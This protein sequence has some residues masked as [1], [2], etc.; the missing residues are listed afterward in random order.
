MVLKTLLYFLCTGNL[1]STTLIG[2]EWKLCPSSPQATSRLHL[3][4]LEKQFSSEQK[5]HNHVQSN[6][7]LLEGRVKYCFPNAPESGSAKHW[8]RLWPCFYSRAI[9]RGKNLHLSPD[10]KDEDKTDQFPHSFKAFTSLKKKKKYLGRGE[11]S[12]LLWFWKHLLRPILGEHLKVI[13]YLTT[14][15][16]EYLMRFFILFI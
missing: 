1:T 7:R 9:T 4:I 16:S 5:R 15:I 2:N 12:L 3:H 14:T 10:W 6:G 8:K 13:R 11:S